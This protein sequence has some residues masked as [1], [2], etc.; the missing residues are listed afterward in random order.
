MGPPDGT[1]VVHFVGTPYGN[2]RPVRRCPYSIASASLSTLALSGNKS[3]FAPCGAA[4]CVLL[5]CNSK[6]LESS[7][8]QTQFR[9][10]IH[11]RGC[12]HESRSCL[13]VSS[14]RQSNDFIGVGVMGVNGVGLGNGPTNWQ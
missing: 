3:I 13:K 14:N 11:C 5:V 4:G 10:R 7:I 9:P 8:K 6:S 12:S 1:T 2:G